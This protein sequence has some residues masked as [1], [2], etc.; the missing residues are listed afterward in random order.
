[1]GLAC[2]KEDVKM[3]RAI[4]GVSTDNL[5]LATWRVNVSTIRT[6]LWLVRQPASPSFPVPCLFLFSRA[7]QHATSGASSRIPRTPSMSASSVASCAVQLWGNP[8]HQHAI[9]GSPASADTPVRHGRTACLAVCPWTLRFLLNAVSAPRACAAMPT[10]A[11]YTPHPP[12]PSGP[13]QAAAWVDAHARPFF[14]C[15]FTTYSLLH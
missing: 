7:S 15:T 2:R 10:G 5:R 6:M 1:M 13:D 3:L 4:V 14:V 8:I 11:F 9:C 12:F